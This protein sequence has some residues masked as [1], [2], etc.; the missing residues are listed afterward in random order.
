MALVYFKFVNSMKTP[1]MALHGDFCFTDGSH[2]PYTARV[3]L[4]THDRTT[5][6]WQNP[7]SSP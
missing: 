6:K 5:E 7:V 3:Q 2:C 1:E 4:L